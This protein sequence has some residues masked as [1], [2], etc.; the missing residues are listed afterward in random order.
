MF[1]S[2]LSKV[3]KRFPITS[4]LCLS[5]LTACV[6]TDPNLNYTPPAGLSPNTAATIIGAQSMPVGIYKKSAIAFAQAIDNQVLPNGDDGWKTPILV[7]PGTHLIQL[8][9]CQHE[10]LLGCEA[11]GSIT[12]STNFE[13]GKT[14]TLQAVLMNAG[15]LAEFTGWI[16]DS[17]GARISDQG[18]AAFT[19][20]QQTVIPVFIPVH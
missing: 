9:A 4:V 17:S 15:R 16:A 2:K 8:G 12:L 6:P 1:M 7:T 19:G 3:E 20:T 18:T 11:F 13:A 10:V 5:L 14:Y